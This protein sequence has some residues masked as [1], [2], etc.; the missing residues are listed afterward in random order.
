M[1]YHR[2]KRS[3]GVLF[4]E[5]YQIGLGLDLLVPANP[6]SS[7][8][9]AHN[10]NWYKQENHLTDDPMSQKNPTEHE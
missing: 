10:N 2:K 4:P 3:H 8:A 7:P 6:G 5:I 9:I 1:T